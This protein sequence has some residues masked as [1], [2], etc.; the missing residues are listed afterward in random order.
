MA[1]PLCLEKS[2]YLNLSHSARPDGERCLSWSGEEKTHLRNHI[3]SSPF[4]PTPAIA[5][6]LLGEC[7]P[8]SLRRCFSGG[9]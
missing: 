8:A 2:N 6:P 1:L 3:R 4:G 5:S 7:S 9:N